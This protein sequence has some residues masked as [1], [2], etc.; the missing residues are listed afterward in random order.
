MPSGTPRRPAA[1]PT[2]TIE[3]TTIATTCR[4]V[5]PIVRST[6]VSRTRRRVS[7]RTVSKTPAHGDGDEDEPEGGDHALEEE[8]ALV[9]ARV[10]P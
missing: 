3:A 4:G 9:R 1:R 2:G 5:I 10:L 8:E 7:R 6:A